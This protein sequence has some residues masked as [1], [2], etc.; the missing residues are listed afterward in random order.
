MEVYPYLAQKIL[1]KMAS[2]YIARGQV[3]RAL[4]ALNQSCQFDT[5][6]DDDN[7]ARLAIQIAEMYLIPLERSFGMSAPRA[8]PFPVYSVPRLYRDRYSHPARSAR[9]RYRDLD[10]AWVELQVALALLRINRH[11]ITR[12]C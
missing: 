2:V 6:L 1:G 11:R 8:E 12:Y 4:A 10:R 3:P 5:D 7:T 9:S